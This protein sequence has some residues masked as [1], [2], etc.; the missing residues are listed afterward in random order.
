MSLATYL[1][2]NIHSIYNPMGKPIVIRKVN[3]ARNIF[4]NIFTKKNI[5]KNISIKLRAQN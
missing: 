3:M 1:D 5:L 2:E 4:G